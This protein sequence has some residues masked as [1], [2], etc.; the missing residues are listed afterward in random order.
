MADTTGLEQARQTAE[1]LKAETT[2][3]VDEKPIASQSTQAKKPTTQIKVELKEPE[4]EKEMTLEVIEPA[5]IENNQLVLTPKH[6]ALIKTQIAAN[7]TAAV[8]YHRIF[9]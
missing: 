3:K 1:K 4:A 6:L 9:G 2:K 7:A 8:S 5:K